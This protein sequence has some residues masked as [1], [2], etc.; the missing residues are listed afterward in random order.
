MKKRTYYWSW[1]I[2]GG[3][4]LLIVQLGLSLFD[5]HIATADSRVGDLHIMILGMVFIAVG[6]V[7]R[8]HQRI[9]VLEAKMKEVEV[10][11]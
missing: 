7:A 1:Y 10:E 5:S 8:L 11:R 9:D 4:V 3:M 6:V 2:A